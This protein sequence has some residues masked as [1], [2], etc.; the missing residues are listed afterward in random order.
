MFERCRCAAYEYV[1]MYVPVHLHCSLDSFPAEKGLERSPRRVTEAG[2]TGIRRRRRQL[3]EG[4][5][6]GRAK[7]H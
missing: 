5:K 6:E 7:V 1:C 4:R 2:G 3:E